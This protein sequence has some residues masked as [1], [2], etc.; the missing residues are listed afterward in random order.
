M[1]LFAVL[2]LGFLSIMLPGGFLALALLRKTKLHIFE[3]LVI[4]FILGMI[5]PPVAIWLES[6]L[7]PF[8]SFFSFSE[9]L[10]NINVVIITII[11]IA[12]CVQQHAFDGLI[13]IP[14]LNVAS[15]KRAS[16][17][18]Y[19]ERVQEL[20]STLH[21]LK[22]DTKIIEEHEKEEEELRE[23]HLNE[24]EMLEGAGPE[25]KAK[26]AEE[27]KAQE[28]R[29]FEAHEQEE[30]RLI[31]GTAKSIGKTRDNSTTLV[32]GILILIM[33]LTFASRIANIHNA[34]TF[35]EFDP[36]Y[37][38]IST[39]YILT[40]GYQ[41][42]LEHAAWPTLVNGTVHRIQPLVPYMEAYWYKLAETPQQATGAVS[43][44]PG[45]TSFTG[46][47]SKYTPP[48]TTLLSLVSSYTVPITA[49]LLVFVVFLFL[50]HQYGKFPA[51]IGAG[52]T[53]AMPALIT[54]FIAGEQLLE[55]WGIFAMFFFFATYLLA[56]Q[57]PEEKRFAILAGIAFASNF[58]GAHYYTVPTGILALY[59][60]LQ[61]TFN[62]LKRA[63]MDNF[64]KLNLIV[65]GVIVIFYILYSPYGA[66]LEKRI[67]AFLGIPIIVSFPLA[68]LIFVALFDY[69]PKFFAKKKMLFRKLDNVEYLAWLGIFALLVLL[70]IAFT[71]IGKPIKSYMALSKKFTTPSS[72]LFM[73]VQEYEPTGIGYNFGA[74]GFGI[75]GT[76]IFGVNLLIFS[77]LIAFA[78]LLLY[79]IFYKESQ[80]GILTLA[81]VIPLAV[82]GISEVK[83][84][85]HFGVAYIIAISVIIGEAL[86]YAKK[87]YQSMIPVIYGVAI[88]AVL[89]E[90]TISLGFGVVGAATN[91]NCT[92]I[93]QTNA[94]GADMFCNTV[95]QYWLSAA[96][97]MRANVGP[98][99]PRIL[100]WWDYGDWINWFGNSNAVIRG[101][102]SVPQTDYNTAAQFVLGKSDGYSANTLAGFMDKSQAQYVLFDDQL[103]P[104][105]GA[106]DFLACIDTNQTTMKY[107]QQQGAAQGSPYVLGTS[108]CELS[109][110]PAELLIPANIT[111]PSEMC[112]F[113][114]SSTVAVQGFVIT[115]SVV[116]Q[117]L[118]YCVPESAL[119]TGTTVKLLNSTGG[120]TNA[121]LSP[122]LYQGLTRVSQTSAF[123]TFV[124]LYTPNAPNGTITNA[125]SAFYDSNFYNGYFLGNLPGF[126]L[127]YPSNF[128]GINYVNSTHRIMIFKLDNYTGGVPTHTQKPASAVNNYTVPG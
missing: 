15:I 17:A 110:D 68:A 6:Y 25:E 70:V 121:I 7:I 66:T 1:E 38:M 93:S 85:P 112:S 90:G 8:S 88:A 9:G 20:R 74:A 100:S 120:V 61:G 53:A 89:I 35:F 59:I 79:A 40:Y 91:S 113:S 80:S 2:L 82:A 4:G 78:A 42:Y 48:N 69:V 67:P 75:I 111:S 64:Y 44:F 123:Y 72:P 97:W 39:Q 96:S 86:S 22:V 41:I 116:D 57:N 23:R 24:S 18:D 60:V 65:L 13:D 124:L 118:T 105:W 37:D 54:T 92:T 107:A 77:V 29:L 46:P 101:D 56:V 30:R 99:A 31:G 5:F 62:V 32:Y 109:H 27:H 95:P 58:L 106:L 45:N 102:N 76:S 87:N 43:N 3:I 115:G 16:N 21:G 83:Y 47:A 73:T 128:T 117:N 12:L 104:K 28:K 33:A 34:A 14:K 94:I 98:Y 49:A 11:G 108:P 52:L 114:N 50:Y 119:Q 63:K 10:Y 55:P 103:V 36:Y 84:L 125:P 127:V 71:P 122:Q 19:K 126:T 26:I 51:L 81:F